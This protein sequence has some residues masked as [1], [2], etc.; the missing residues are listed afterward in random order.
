MAEHKLTAMVTGASSG[1]GTEFVR[2]LADRCEVI[3]AVARRADR[4]QSLA[5]ELDP[6]CE[7]H[8]IGADLTTIEGLT[9]TLEALRQQ[10]PVDYLINNAGF[11]PFGQFTQAPL[12]GQREML[13][14]H[15]DAVITLCRAAIPFM[16]ERGGGAIVNVSSLGA[17]L[18]GKGI[19]VYGAS[20]AFLNYFSQALQ[21]EVAKLDISVQALCPGYVRT[22]FHDVMV[23]EGFDRERIPQDMWMEAAQVVQASLEALGNGQVIVVPGECNQ[24][25]A[26]AALDA[27]LA[28]F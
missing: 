8:C 6:R 5:E 4:L 16:Q 11:A 22:E 26:R 27:Q 18:P 9:R 25:L 7:V 20:K 21:A 17:L 1:L 2:Q 19:A 10:G 13:S 28:S 12:D 14:L 24:A 3:I 15:C 23:T